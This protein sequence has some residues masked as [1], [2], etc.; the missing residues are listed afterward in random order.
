M[1]SNIVLVLE[2]NLARTIVFVRPMEGV[3]HLVLPTVCHY[4]SPLGGTKSIVFFLF[5]TFLMKDTF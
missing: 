2:S 4:L 5:F 3:W 1:V